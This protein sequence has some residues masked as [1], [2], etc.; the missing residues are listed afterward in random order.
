MVDPISWSRD[1]ENAN[2]PCLRDFMQFEA[3]IRRMYGD[4]DCRQKAALRAYMETKQGN[5]ESVHNY[6]ARIRSTWRDTE[7]D[8]SSPAAQ[9]IMYDLA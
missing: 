6:V 9:R 3:E 1:L 8:E 4:K 2:L 7:W 5:D